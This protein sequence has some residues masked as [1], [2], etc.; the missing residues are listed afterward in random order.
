MTEQNLKEPESLQEV[1]KR[2]EW[3]AN[4]LKQQASYV[5]TSKI[6]GFME[7]KGM[8]SPHD[9]VVGLNNPFVNNK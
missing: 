7:K 2:C 3:E 8:S 5:Y 6:T 1:L 4:L 9:Y